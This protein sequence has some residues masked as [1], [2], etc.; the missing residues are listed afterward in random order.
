MPELAEPELAEQREESSRFKVYTKKGDDGTTGLFGGSRVSKANLRIECLGLV[1]TVSSWV[2]RIVSE[3]GDDYPEQKAQLRQI[4]HYLFDCQSDIANVTGRKQ[5]WRMTGDAAQYL[6]H[7]IDH[8]DADL[9]P[10][11]KFILPGGSLAASDCHV[12]RT[13]TRN[14]ER[15]VVALAN[16][17]T[18]NPEVTVFMNRLS[19]YFFTLARV[20]NMLAGV[21]DEVM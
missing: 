4:Q 18:L 3:L 7:A 5:S 12:A 9:Q 10:L 15:Q 19:D 16:S 20:L 17:E 11:N 8:Y 6:E 2:G 13:L 1:D 14:A 21:A